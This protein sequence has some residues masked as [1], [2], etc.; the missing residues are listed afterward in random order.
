MNTAQRQTAYPL[1]TRSRGVR[2]RRRGT[3]WRH[4]RNRLCQDVKVLLGQDVALLDELIKKMRRNDRSLGM[5]GDK[6]DV[7][8]VQVVYPLLITEKMI[9]NPAQTSACLYSFRY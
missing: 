7:G 5:C 3:L 1:R 8:L 4:S 2:E 6:N 9:M